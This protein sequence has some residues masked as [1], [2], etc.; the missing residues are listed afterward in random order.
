MTEEALIF[1]SPYS[2]DAEEKSC[3]NVGNSPR[4]DFHYHLLLL[5][6]QTHSKH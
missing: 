2:R 4:D 3:I 1:Y 5:E 6:S